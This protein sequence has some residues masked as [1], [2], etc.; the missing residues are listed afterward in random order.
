MSAS[1]AFWE[2]EFKQF[3]PSTCPAL[4]LLLRAGSG[5][6]EGAGVQVGSLWPLPHRSRSA[7]HLFL[8]LDCPELVAIPL[9]GYVG[10]GQGQQLHLLT[11]K[12]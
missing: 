6:T 8:A 4:S 3:H 12:H 11:G 9:P 7:C 5:A 1:G 2:L 10:G